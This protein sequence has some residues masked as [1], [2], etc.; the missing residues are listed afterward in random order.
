MR[1]E[2][3]KKVLAVLLISFYTVNVYGNKIKTYTRFP[4]KREN[5]RGMFSYIICDVTVIASLEF[6]RVFVMRII[7]HC[8]DVSMRDQPWGLRKL[9]QKVSTF[10]ERISLM[11]LKTIIV[12]YGAIYVYINSDIIA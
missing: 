6:D 1:Q 12:K 4:L 7:R 2:G 5:I 10:C 9:T 8:C 11:K 3:E